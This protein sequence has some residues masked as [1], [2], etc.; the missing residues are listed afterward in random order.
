MRLFLA[1]V[2]FV[3]SATAFSQISLP[4][5]T[6]V[7]ENFN[8]I[9]SS[10]TTTLPAGWRMSPTGNA[11]GAWS[12]GVSTTTQA[13]NSGL[14][15]TGGR[16]NWATSAGTDRAIG[17][18]TSAAYAS[19]NAVMAHY[20]NTTGGTVNTVTISFG[21]ERYVVNTA[22][23]SV[24]F[25][26]STDGVTWTPQSIA[27][28][29]TNEFGPGTAAGSFSSPATITKGA[30]VAVTLANDADIYFRWV[31]TNTGSTNA[32]GLGLDNVSVYAGTAT[33]VL[34]A[35]LKDLLQVDNGNQNQFNEGDVIRYRTTIKNIGSGHATD[36]QINIPPP[37]NTTLVSGSIKTSAVA[38]DDKYATS[39]N[40]TLSG[41]SV[42]AN[43]F[44]VPTPT[45]VLTYG[46]TADATATNA[47]AV[48]TTDAGGTIALNANGT[49]TYTPPAGFSGVDRIKYITG[50]G[51]LPNN[52]A[53][54]TITVAPDI[55]F[56]TTN[57]DPSCNGG[58]NGSI[59]FNASGGNG[60]L[61]YSIT[62]AAG[63][64]Q[65]S[66]TFTG[67]S[68][69]TYNLAVKD[70]GGYIKTGTATINNPAVVVVSG[71][72]PNQVYNTAMTPV[73]FTKTGGTGA[74]AW[75]I[76]GQPTGM[77]INASTGQVSGTP[78]QTGSFT[79]T[80]TATDVN[81][82]T[83]SI[84]DA[85]TVAPNLSNDTYNAVVGNTQLVADGHSA[86]TTP[87]TTS[88]TNILGNDASDAAISVTPGT[89]ATAN[90][91]SITINAAGKFIYS[92]LAGSTAAD[93]Y[94]YTATSNGISTTATINFTVANMV[95]YVNNT[96]A[97]ANG[98]ANGTSHRP[99]TTVNAATAASAINQVIY[100]HTGS[101]NTTGA[102]VL[103]SGQTLQ[104]A[105]N[106]FSVGILFIPAGTKPTL[107]GTVTLANSVKVDG[108]DM[109][110]GTSTAITNAGTTVTGIFVDLGNI[111]TT[112]GTGV[113]VTGIGNTGT[114]R[115]ASVSTGAAVNG[116]NVTN[117]SSPGTLLINSGTITNTT[118][119][120]INLS[121]VTSVG[122]GGI[123]INETTQTALAISATSVSLNGGLTIA[124]SGG[125]TGISV[126]AG[127]SSINASS[128]AFRI[129]NTGAGQG[130]VSSGGTFS[131]T[132]SNSI[133]STQTGTAL[134]LTNTTVGSSGILFTSVSSNGAANGINLT[135]V[136]NPG[137]IYIAVGTLTGGAGAAVNI[138]GG[139]AGFFFGGS[140]SQA[141]VGQPLV[142]ISGYT[143][144]A[145]FNDGTLQATNGTGLQFSNVG[146]TVNFMGTTTLA[147][148]DAGINI[149]SGSTGTFNFGTN[150]TSSFTI[151]NPTGIAINVNASAA[152]V[153]YGGSFTKNNNA[154][155]GISITNNT[156]GTININGA[157]T[158]TLS[159]QTANA[160]NIT[161]NSA[162]TT[163]NF[164]GNN[165]SI[166]TTT[167][168]GFNATGSGNVSI[169]GTGNQITA[170]TGRAINID[171]VLIVSPGITLQSV[172]ATGA[173]TNTIHL[174]NAGSG[175]FTI[176]GTGTTAGSGGTINH[177]SAGTTDEV[178]SIASHSFSPNA[179]ATGIGIYIN[180]TNNISLSN[181][182]FTGTFG[183]FAIR[184]DAVNNFILRES[185]FTGIYGTNNSG[186][187]QEGA[188]RFGVQSD[189]GFGNGLTGAAQFIG[190]NIAGGYTDNLAI[191]NNN[192]GSLNISFLDG[193]VR[194]AIFGN[195]GASTGNDAILI[196][197]R[198]N[199]G[200][201]GAGFNLT[202]SAT[203]V[204]FNGARGDLIQTVAASNSTQNITITNNNFKN[205]HPGIVSGGGG[206][207]IGGGGNTS[208]YVVTYNVSNNVFTGAVGSAIYTG[209]GGQSGAI[210]G[211]IANNTIGTPNGTF[212][213][214]QNLAG[215][216]GGGMG[217]FVS[218]EK[219]SGSGLLRHAV[220][221]EGNTVTDLKDAAAG[222]YLRSN[223]QGGGT[224]LL[225]ATVKN[226][227]VRELGGA[228]QY[229]A[230]YSVVG[231]SSLSDIGIMGLNLTGNTFNNT[232]GAG[233][234]AENAVVIDQIAQS[235][236]YYFPGYAGSPNGESWGGTASA[237][238]SA[239]L[240]D[241]TR[242]NILTNGNTPTRPAGKVFADPVFSVAG[243][244]FTL[245]IP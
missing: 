186:G 102:A 187:V 197:T 68:A 92:P 135:N 50:N 30:T 104:G 207:T 15:A 117:F 58:S 89:F 95:W 25:F 2:A 116:V 138:S 216:T 177:T 160:V 240:Q 162:G 181:I 194:P 45:A 149:L 79:A 230:F 127:T 17:F 189:D 239:F 31:F 200:A 143:G 126:G 34:I 125:G 42:L 178:Y 219:F 164:S 49:F 188:I 201:A 91:G 118:A 146:G 172:N 55:M 236:R 39:F 90:G 75:S 94:T 87:H 144:T 63:T 98:A 56:T 77:I 193:S 9:G 121:S 105:G 180:N 10:A 51:N 83:G 195:N 233:A 221:I 156:G 27:D 38:V 131:F 155:T 199:G 142:N 196:E 7:T 171:G 44:G 19:P 8:A 157:S 28:V 245:P 231:G 4:L 192:T 97:G 184:G 208:N 166:T 152:N 41:S 182:N 85:F 222:I 203:G 238:L 100:V 54:V 167:G 212:D 72:I 29:S 47:G 122:L 66:N 198:G 243:T 101:G 73:T 70:A 220:R 145:T 234:F 13:A 106:N 168:T 24:A 136:S 21:I 113:S 129:T 84:S 37:S 48:R 161:G 60:T 99:F 103:K 36:V 16:Y 112:T 151:F 26:S 123:T 22:T 109:N 64:F 33:P 153:N 82:C 12:A 52:D 214:T 213:Q 120:G 229:T 81:G 132:G 88:A 57:A 206:I 67:L 170:G 74:I 23:A 119:A 69:G 32:Q 134:N 225:E 107:S 110:T 223:N 158:K 43:D 78:T 205:M 61:T 215:S 53:V 174:K 185:N 62:G 86:P 224:G 96:Y 232:A 133:I 209:F 175:G 173:A 139:N 163:V 237:G 190:N 217:I 211:V 59:T 227:I 3:F 154:T 14:P 179:F 115:F 141:T 242:N 65:A 46:T 235:A 108:F 124:T 210:N 137:S 128:H 40:T 114:M 80:I 150:F 218:N 111:T 76:S 176:T 169:A 159:T 1:M 204:D 140:A 244:A 165:L 241:A 147:G 71:D 228:A 11:V 202:F 35:T 6:I 93:S 191:F 226:N 130:L 5:N 148:G 20:R 183:N 18:L